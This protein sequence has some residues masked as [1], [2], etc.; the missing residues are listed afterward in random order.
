MSSGIENRLTVRLFAGSLLT[1]DIKMQ[2]KHS[3][4]WKQSKIANESDQRDLV[5]IRFH[6]KEYIGKYISLQSLTL[7]DLREIETTIAASLKRYCPELAEEALKIYVFPQ[8]FV[9]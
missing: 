8:V 9:S 4:H 1:F 2:L 3:P 7:D 5:E 6:N